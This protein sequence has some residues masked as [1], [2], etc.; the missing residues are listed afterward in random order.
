MHLELQSLDDANGD[1]I[2]GLKY[3]LNVPFSNIVTGV[4]LRVSSGRT[5]Q[6]GKIALKVTLED[7]ACLDLVV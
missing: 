2:A 6:E 5:R 4:I 7:T 3:V 1:Y